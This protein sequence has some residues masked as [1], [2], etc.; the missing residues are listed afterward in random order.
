MESVM[1]RYEVLDPYLDVVGRMLN[2]Q[3]VPTGQWPEKM[4]LVQ[5]AAKALGDEQRFRPLEL[6]VRFDP[7]GS[8][9]ANGAMPRPD[10]ST[11]TDNGHGVMQ[12]TCFHCG[13]CDLGCPAEARTT[14]ALTYVPLAKKHGTVVRPLH[15]VRS[16]RP[17]GNGYVVEFDRI[18]GGA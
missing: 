14:L 13:H 17:E 7:Q 10:P 16:I 18:E 2:V 8:L 3:T 11:Y 12:G 1:E 9:D 6:A 5:R 4:K 15:R